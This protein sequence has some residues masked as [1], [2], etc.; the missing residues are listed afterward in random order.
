MTPVDEGCFTAVLADASPGD[1]Y[2]YVLDGEGPFPDPASRFQP[3][4]VHGPSEIIDPSSFVW[5]DDRWT[6]VSI[7]DAVVYELHVGTFTKAGTLAAASERL[8]YLADLGVTVVELMPLADFPGS[9]NWG[10]D[11][12]SLFAPSHNYGRP[13]DL[14]RFVDRAHRLGLAVVLDV[15]YNHFG[16]DGAYASVFSPFYFSARH[17]SPWGAAVN[18]DGE[19]ADHV[20]EFFIENA[21]HWIHEYHFDGLRLDA[22]H[23]LIDDSP[24]HFVAELAARVRAS[25]SERRAL[26][27]A[28]DDR[29]LAALVRPL[30]EDGWGLDGVWADDFHHQIRRLAAGDRDG[31]YEDFTG[32]T[33]DLATTIR[34]GWFYRGQFS[35]HQGK[36][37]GTAPT[38][39]PPCR[40]VV[41]IQNH[42]QVGNRPFG[43]RLHHQIEPALYRALTALL[44]FTPHTPLLFMGQEW[45]A[46]S[47][48]LFFT[49]H[50]PEL[51]RLV[52]EG[53]RAEFSRFEA[54]AN[55]ET[56]LLI[57]DP[58]ALSTFERSRLAWDELTQPQHSAVLE[59]YRALL[60][61]RRSEIALKCDPVEACAL[62]DAS[63]VLVRRGQHEAWL[64]AMNTNAKRHLDLTR[65]RSAAPH[66]RWHLA[67]STEDPR[68]REDG[69]TPDAVAL[70]NGERLTIS[71]TGPA[72]AILKG[73]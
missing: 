73:Q 7:E 54:F 32:T 61:L 29:N 4:G 31:Y 3:Q 68:F 63:I 46:S 44:L 5:S 25:L 23:G 52:T 8:P 28:E 34:E 16:P 70:D 72:A 13:D 59:L 26:L 71:F 30:R 6:G 55:C 2:A 60:R 10:Y 39:V 9:R 43:R 35:V 65:W 42:D 14:R 36:P 24:R 69:N 22:T 66:E 11:G 50:N 45:A 21:L 12:S 17:R 56:R 33:V 58:Q 37:R 1:L 49:D 18:L 20:R 64:L 48:F 40:M 27:I 62:D 47:P 57:P 67:L 38:G 53:R 15:V 41:C 19:G 51:G